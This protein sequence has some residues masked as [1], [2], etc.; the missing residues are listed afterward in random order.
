MSRLIDRPVRV[1]TGRDGEPSSFSYRGRVYRVEAVLDR[2]EE[3][4]EWWE[5]PVERTVYRVLAEGGV[6]ELE[7]RRPEHRWYL[8]RA[9]D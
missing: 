7:W 5:A 3:V 6:F 1:R 2:W 4:G 8:Y 9:Y